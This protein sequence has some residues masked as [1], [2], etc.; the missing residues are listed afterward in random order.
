PSLPFPTAIVSQYTPPPAHP[1]TD[2]E[3][4][5]HL[6]CINHI[7]GVHAI[8][9]HLL[10]TIMEHPESGLYDSESIAHIFSVNLAG[11]NLKAGFQYSLGDKHS[12][13]PK[14]F[15]YFFQDKSGKHVMCYKLH[16]SCE[17]LQSF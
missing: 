3:I 10:G 15:C 14:A 13:H 2:E 9:Y 8:V 17:F 4:N 5:L 6:N 11:D 1:F 7:T 16:T 12:G